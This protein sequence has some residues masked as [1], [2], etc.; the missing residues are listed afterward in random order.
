[1]LPT[2]SRVSLLPGEELLML[3]EECR[4]GAAL[5][6]GDATTA[7]APGAAGGGSAGRRLAL[8]AGTVFLVPFPAFSLRSSDAAGLRAA[9]G[10]GALHG[11]ANGRAAERGRQAP[12]WAA[13]PGGDGRGRHLG[14]DARADEGADA[15]L[16]DAAAVQDLEDLHGI[17]ALREVLERHE[18]KEV[19]EGGGESASRELDGALADCAPLVPVTGKW[20]T[21]GE[22][23]HTE[24]EGEDVR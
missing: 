7:G 1:M 18:A 2:L 22:L 8:F 13:G 11:H 16:V 14:S 9:S 17:E 21:T 4:E 5:L 23:V 12:G 6:A 15:V 20:G 10:G 24:A 3:F 19:R